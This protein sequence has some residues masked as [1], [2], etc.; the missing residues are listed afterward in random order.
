[1]SKPSS[2]NKANSHKI[3]YSLLGMY[4]DSDDEDESNTSDEVI[5]YLALPKEVQE[6]D[7]LEWWK[8]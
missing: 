1:M 6:C 8:A 5:R 3:N 7:P 2:T 4:E